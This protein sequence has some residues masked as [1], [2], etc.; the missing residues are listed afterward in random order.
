[1]T[2]ADYYR[3]REFLSD[4]DIDIGF[5]LFVP[6]LAVLVFSFAEN[7]GETYEKRKVFPS[8]MSYKRIILLYSLAVILLASFSIISLSVFICERIFEKEEVGAFFE[9]EFYERDY[10]ALLSLEGKPVF[11]IVRVQHLTEEFG[12]DMYDLVSPVQLPYGIKRYVEASSFDS[13]DKSFEVHFDGEVSCII[14]LIRPVIY[15]SYKTLEKEFL[16]SSGDFCGS[17]KSDKFHFLKCPYARRIEEENFI[18][19]DNIEEARLFGYEMC[20][21]CNNH[22]Y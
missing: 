17:K 18:Y 20:D 12:Y 5:A 15:S 1:M 8:L 2:F 3:L 9:A 6:A 7:A 4:W 11:C 19:F 21:Y 13:F 14:T 22:Y 10:E 16:S